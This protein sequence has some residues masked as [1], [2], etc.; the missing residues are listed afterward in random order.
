MEPIADLQ[1]IHKEAQ[2]NFDGPASHLTAYSPSLNSIYSEVNGAP[3]HEHMLA[4]LH[5]ALQYLLQNPGIPNWIANVKN[6]G[7]LEQESA[8]WIA[9]E[10]TTVVN[11]HGIR[12]LA[13]VVPESA[14]GEAAME[15][16]TEGAAKAGVEG[17]MFT[18]LEEAKRWIKEGQ[19]EQAVS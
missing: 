10:Y 15:Q 5:A 19:T 11:Q 17:K 1:L 3:P 8:D 16:W 6:M 14:F 2:E 18:D 4:P 7:I 12:R 9:N 13:N